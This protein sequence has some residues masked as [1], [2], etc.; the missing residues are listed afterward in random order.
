V[1]IPASD[2]KE[3]SRPRHATKPLVKSIDFAGDAEVVFDFVCDPHS[4]QLYQ[5]SLVALSQHPPVVNTTWWFAGSKFVCRE[6]G[7]P[8]R[9][10]FEV[11]GVPVT[12]L[13]SRAGASRTKVTL[14]VPKPLTRQALEVAEEQWSLLAD[15][16]KFF[17]GTVG[18]ADSTRVTVTF[19]SGKTA[20]FPSLRVCT[21]A[22]ILRPAA[23]VFMMVVG[24]PSVFWTWMVDRRTPGCLSVSESWPDVGSYYEYRKAARAER[25][26]HPFS[27]FDEGVVR[28][29]SV[30][31]N[32][33]ATL[34]EHQRSVNCHVTTTHTLST[35]NCQGPATLLKSEYL[36][37]V[38]HWLWRRTMAS[39]ILALLPAEMVK[40]TAN[41]IRACESPLRATNAGG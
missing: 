19:F 10:S 39:G 26:L 37:E 11:D 13:F 40:Q 5:P 41:I 32:R 36:F 1:D 24:D 27:R 38:R 25:V 23:E 14:E 30:E 35:D 22:L 8:R 3:P 20:S 9:Y 28:V 15:L 16:Q 17:E 33:R 6:V 2:G 21:E 34:E 7:R 18:T 31:V 4:W 29:T 12:Y